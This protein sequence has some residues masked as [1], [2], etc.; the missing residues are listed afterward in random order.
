MVLVQVNHHGFLHKQKINIFVLLCCIS[1][2]KKRLGSAVELLGGKPNFL[3]LCFAVELAL[4]C[5]S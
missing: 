5:T 2:L 4:M 3:S 1:Y